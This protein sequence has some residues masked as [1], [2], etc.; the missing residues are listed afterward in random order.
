MFILLKQSSISLTI[1]LK[2]GFLTSLDQT[3]CICRPG[4]TDRFRRLTRSAEFR[5][6]KTFKIA[7]GGL[8]VFSILHLYWIAYN[9]GL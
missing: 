2:V 4:S 8:H 6:E 1:F 7:I 9:H 5:R 3:H